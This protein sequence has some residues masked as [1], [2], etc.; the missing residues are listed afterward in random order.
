M[1]KWSGRVFF[2]TSGAANRALAQGRYP[3]FQP[4]SWKRPDRGPRRDLHREQLDSIL[5]TLQYG[6]NHMSARH[7]QLL[8]TLLQDAEERN[9]HRWAPQ[10][11]GGVSDGLRSIKGE[12]GRRQSM[13]NG[14]VL[15]ERWPTALHPR[16]L[17]SW[18]VQDAST[19][20]DRWAQFMDEPS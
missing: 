17:T 11:L 7:L 14:E 16:S 5:I 13:L 19:L 9:R 4:E 12:W 8:E 10:T 20:E 6:L 15:L 2:P 18:S 1:P 3:R